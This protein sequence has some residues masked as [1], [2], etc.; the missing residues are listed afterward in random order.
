MSEDGAPL[1]SRYRLDE[2]IGEGGMGV[3]WRG[4]DHASGAVYAIKLL[5][6]ELAGDPAAL[7]RFVRERNALIRLRHPGIVAVHDMIVEGDRL[8]LVMDLVRGEDLRA[9]RLRRGGT[10]PPAESAWLM[11]QICAAL[12]AVHA[13]D[14][15]HRDLKPA[16]VLLDHARPSWPVRL[17]DFGI[18]RVFDDA[19]VTSAGRIT[20]TPAYLAPE[21]LEGSTPG[22]PADVYAAGITLYE[23]VA[24]RVPFR[25]EHFG[26]V[27]HAH[28]TASPEPVAGVPSALW[29]VIESC[30]AKDPGGRPDAE[31]LGHRLLD[32]TEIARTGRLRLSLPDGAG[33]GAGGSSVSPSSHPSLSHPSLSPP[34]RAAGT[35]PGTGTGTGGGTGEGTGEGAAGTAGQGTEDGLG[36]AKDTVGASRPSR[37][38]WIV[39]TASVAV[40]LAVLGAV[41]VLAF[42]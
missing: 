31:T 40:A 7:T 27:M 12:A 28:L 8:A 39:V 5:R 15:V 37:R 30:L 33:S 11:A 35:G 19:T 32:F 1:G 25:G 22:P 16:N 41:A 29:S 20:G 14:M 9:Y 23:L 24:G 13:G 17:A 4:H 38:R 42:A 2:P 18:A 21:L 36:G 10:L 26:A 34:S 6:P 3:V